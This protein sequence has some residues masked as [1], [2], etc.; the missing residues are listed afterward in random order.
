VCACVCICVLNLSYKDAVASNN[1]Y[2]KTVE[3]FQE[4]DNYTE[5]ACIPAL[6]LL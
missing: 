4:H 3:L 2:W 5:F 1:I 6:S